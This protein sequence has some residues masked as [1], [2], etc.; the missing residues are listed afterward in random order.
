MPE[1]TRGYKYLLVIIDSFSRYLDLHPIQDLTA[2]TAL[3]CF[4]QFTSN[5]GTPSHVCCDNGS[6]FHGIF[7]EF[8]ELLRVNHVRTH[9]YSHQE[10]GI[11]EMRQQGDSY[12]SL[13][14]SPRATTTR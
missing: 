10:N 5:F 7:R 8:L 13:S 6:Q 12:H 9:P 1:S 14:L 4:L 11:V 3:T 2:L